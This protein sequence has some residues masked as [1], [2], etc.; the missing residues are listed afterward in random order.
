MKKSFYLVLAVFAM[1][2]S[3]GK[4]GVKANLDGTWEVVY[5][6]GTDTYTFADGTYTYQSNFDKFEGSY[7]ING[8]TLTMT[9]EKFWERDYERTEHG[10]PVVGGDGNFVWKA[11]EEVTRED[12]EPVIVDVKFLYDNSVLCFIHPEAQDAYNDHYSGD[13]NVELLLK[14]GS[15]SLPSNLKDIEGYW[16]W[17]H[18]RAIVVIDGDKANLIIEPWGERYEGKAVYS[19]GL[20]RITNFTFYTLRY[21]DPGV[22][23]EERATADEPLD[24]AWRVPG[25]DDWAGPSFG[26]VILPFVADKDIAYSN[27]ANLP[28]TFRKK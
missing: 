16:T 26:E 15:S 7:E 9:P 19:N 5:D 8:V 1:A 21:E 13:E 17:Q 20:L 3:C 24:W 23:E 2:F 27:L 25:P 11:W 18:S 14:K 10:S 6:A 12:A 22:P 4:E 28:A